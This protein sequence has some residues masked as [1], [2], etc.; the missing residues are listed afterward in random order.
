MGG[1]C[2][3][4]LS[5]TGREKSRPF[6]YPRSNVNA[7]PPKPFDNETFPWYIVMD[8]SSVPET[9]SH[10]TIKLS[11]LTSMLDYFPNY[12]YHKLCKIIY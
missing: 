9:L 11:H 5:L 10:L 4:G 7:K 2:L 8:P 3:I 12:N 6:S 1:D